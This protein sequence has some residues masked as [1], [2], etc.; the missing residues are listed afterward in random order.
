MKLVDV[1]R[2]LNDQKKLRELL[3]DVIPDRTMTPT[4]LAEEVGIAPANFLKWFRKNKDCSYRSVMKIII[5]IE[6]QIKSKEIHG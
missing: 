2:Y 6:K 3:W 5:Y 4:T 1:E